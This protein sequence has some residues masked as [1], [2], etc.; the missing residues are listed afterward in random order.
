M[1]AEYEKNNPLRIEHHFDPMGADIA[2]QF[3]LMTVFRIV[4]E[5]ADPVGFRSLAHHL[6]RNRE[7]VAGHHEAY[8]CLP[9]IAIGS[10]LAE[11]HHVTGASVIFPWSRCCPLSCGRNVLLGLAAHH[12]Q[13]L[14]LWY[15]I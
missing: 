13:H 6:V 9:E 10:E 4:S 12:D 7:V 1:P 14:S 5:M 3:M 8:K 2:I 15:A 11:F